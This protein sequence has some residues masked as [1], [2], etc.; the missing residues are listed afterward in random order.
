MKYW[1]HYQNILIHH[2]NGL[3]VS[4][5]Q[6]LIFL[7]NTTVTIGCSNTTRDLSG[8]VVWKHEGFHTPCLVPPCSPGSL[9]HFWSVCSSSATGSLLL[10]S[11]EHSACSHNYSFTKYLEFKV[12]PKNPVPNSPKSLVGQRYSKTAIANEFPLA[13]K[14]SC[15]CH[16]YSRKHHICLETGLS[17]FP[18]FELLEIKDYICPL[19]IL[20][21]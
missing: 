16:C 10:F 18:D 12:K 19:H 8:I 7:L 15:I 11:L 21:S 3:L 17:L 13:P 9:P 20:N 2:K 6:E 1:F 14:A 4:I 5:P